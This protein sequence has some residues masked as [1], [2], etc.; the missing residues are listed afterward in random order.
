VVGRLEER[1]SALERDTD[2]ERAGTGQG[3]SRAASAGA[4]IAAS[5]GALHDP[6]GREVRI[7][8]GELA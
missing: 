5:I 7:Q 8:G 6:D 4:A 1:L 3:R 2:T